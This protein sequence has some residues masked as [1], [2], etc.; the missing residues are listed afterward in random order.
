MVEDG[1]SEEREAVVEAVVETEVVDAEGRGGIGEMKT[2]GGSSRSTSPRPV[3]MMVEGCRGGSRER[4]KNE[5]N[6]PRRE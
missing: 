3:S 1:G 5:R 4:G 2:G 6:E